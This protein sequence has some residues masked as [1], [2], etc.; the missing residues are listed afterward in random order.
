LVARAVSGLSPEKAVAYLKVTNKRAA[1]PVMQ[2][3]Q[4]A[5][6]NAK[7]NLQASPGDLK[8]ETVQV[9][10]GPRGAKRLDKGHGARFDRGVKRRRLAHILVKLN[11]KER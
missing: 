9:L 3:I 2:V 10:E 7:N 8:L 11:V 1:G 4:Q 5:I 6:A